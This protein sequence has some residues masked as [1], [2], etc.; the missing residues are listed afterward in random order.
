MSTDTVLSHPG[1]GEPVEPMFDDGG[2]PMFAGEP[3]IVDND[4]KATWAMRKLLEHKQAIDSVVAIAEAEIARIQQWADE[5][6]AKHAP[7]IDY[8]EGQLIR[9]ARQV[10]EESDGKVKSVSTPY[11]KV[12][13]RA[14]SEKWVIDDDEFLGWARE[15]KPEWVKTVEQRGVDIATL[16]DALAIEPTDTLGLVPITPDGEIIPG[17]QIVVGETTYK[18][19]VAK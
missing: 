4:R 18:V 10:R 6:S 2:N 16:K 8:F 19:E 9:Y 11:G 7:S 3:F 13:S 17:I 1:V 15:S 12:T 5:Q 14:G